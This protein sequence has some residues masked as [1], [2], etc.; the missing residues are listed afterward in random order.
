MSAEPRSCGPCTICCRF[1][2]VAE[3]AKP[4]QEWCPHCGPAGCGIHETRPQPCRNFSCFWLM[5]ENFPED[6]RP[7]LCGIVAAFNG[8]D[9][10]SVVLH[11]DPDRPESLA[12]PPGSE[13]LEALLRAFDP[14]CIVCGEDKMVIHRPEEDG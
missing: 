5:D 9:H 14:V 13:L 4:V 3:I 11:L 1:Y 10:E 7:D 2:A 12:A 6:L 8:E